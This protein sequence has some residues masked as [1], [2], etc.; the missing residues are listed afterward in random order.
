MG[1]FDLN[2]KQT[3]TTY[4]GY[5]DSYNQRNGELTN[6]QYDAFDYSG[7]QRYIK[8]DAHSAV[9]SFRA[10][11]GHHYVF[12]R[13]LSNST[14]VFGSAQAIDNSSAGG[15]T[16]KFPVNVGL[17]STFDAQ[18]GLSEN[19][20][21]SG[22]TGL[23]MQTMNAHPVSYGM[24]ADSTNLEGYNIITSTRSN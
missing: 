12:N 11:I 6:E 4:F 20:K 2:E 5:S 24:S 23:E 14:S 13:H 19:I 8:N 17:R 9:K 22:I 16:E 18:F 21:L 3:L 1:D 7:N 10:G 15:W